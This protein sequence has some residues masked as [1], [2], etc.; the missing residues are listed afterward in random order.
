MTMSLQFWQRWLMVAA[1]GV[2][3]YSSALIVLSDI[4]HNLFNT[5]FFAAPDGAFSKE[6]LN[7]I[8]LVQGVL[9]AVLIGWMLTVISIL[10][11]SFKRGERSA[12]YTVAVPVVVWFVVDA[13]FSLLIGVPAHAVFN[14]LFLILFATPLAATFKTFHTRG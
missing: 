8:R 1:G 14:I 7:Y 6:A 2:M 9:G 3:L 13:G 5:L 12:W 11:S 4:M 10:I